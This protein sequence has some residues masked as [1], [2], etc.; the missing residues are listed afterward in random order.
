MEVVFSL[1]AAALVAVGLF[2]TFTPTGL[3]MRGAG[4]AFRPNILDRR[5]PG[6]RR[7]MGVI[8]LLV[9]AGLAY[10]VYLGKLDF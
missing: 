3:M 9:G 10:A 8:I 6:W 5:L 4:D 1:I 7:A 2:A